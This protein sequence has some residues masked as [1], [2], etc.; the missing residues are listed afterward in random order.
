MA[1]CHDA[2]QFDPL[3]FAQMLPSAIKCIGVD[4]AHAYVALRESALALL[5]NSNTVRE[6]LEIYGGWDLASFMQE[7][8][9]TWR[10]D[11]SDISFFLTIL[12]Y[13]HLD[14]R[15]SY[16]L[17]T[18]SQ[19]VAELLRRSAWGESELKLLISGSDFGV[20]FDH[21]IAGQCLI[22]TTSAIASRHVFEQMRPVSIGS[23]AGW[24]S[25]SEAKK[26]RDRLQ[27]END[28]IRLAFQNSDES[29]AFQMAFEML[30]HAIASDTGLCLIISG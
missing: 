6:L 5:Q 20:F 11:P 24:L 9:P 27:E 26:L 8:P 15:K 25:Y 28:G 4:S 2:Y 13:G 19:R 22:P 10:G 14:P 18:L 16:G 1:I 7:W 21:Y 23:S 17:K 29:M 30:E 12:L 3:V